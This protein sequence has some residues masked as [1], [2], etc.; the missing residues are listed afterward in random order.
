M[1]V[2]LHTPRFIA[3]L[4]LAGLLLGS[5][6]LAPGSLAASSQP[7]ASTFN[8]AAFCDYVARAIARLEAQPPSPLRSFLLAQLYKLQLA[9]C[10]PG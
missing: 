2:A 8:I 1:I 5:S 7:T 4:A 10:S 3:G 6:P 9:Y